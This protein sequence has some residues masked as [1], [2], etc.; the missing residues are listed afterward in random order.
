MG[1]TLC[2]GK[3]VVSQLGI[4]PL[5]VQFRLSLCKGADCYRVNC[6]WLWLQLSHIL[7]YRYINMTVLCTEM[8]FIMCDIEVKQTSAW[9]VKLVN[10]S[11]QYMY[12]WCAS[13]QWEAT[14]LMKPIG[15][16][17]TLLNSVG[18]WLSLAGIMDWSL[19]VYSD[20]D[21]CPIITDWGMLL[22][23]TLESE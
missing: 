5:S 16:T 2:I 15:R 6:P 13:I 4:P 8:V 14:S 19:S 17:S 7:L 10:L 20:R 9:I 12:T 1:T 21:Y 23:T 3:L 11:V 22:P 18:K